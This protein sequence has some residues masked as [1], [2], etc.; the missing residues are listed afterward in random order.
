[1]QNKDAWHWLLVSHVSPA[2]N[3]GSGVG[4]VVGPP[5][6]PGVGLAVGAGVVTGV[7]AAP[8]PRSQQSV[9][10]HGVTK[11]LPFL[12]EQAILTSQ[13]ALGNVPVILLLLRYLRRRR[14]VRAARRPSGT[15]RELAASS[16][17]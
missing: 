7:H 5:V 17:P 1:M 9:E 16:A 11:V 10:P 14:S 4:L 8:S 6:G 3:F 12:T 13:R 2:A 15:R